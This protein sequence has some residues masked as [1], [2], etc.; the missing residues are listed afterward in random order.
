MATVERRV[1]DRTGKT[2]YVVRYRTP[3][4]ASRQKT[5]K[6]R[7]DA[8]RFVTSIESSKMT[9][10]FVDPARQ[11][12]SVADWCDK[13]LAAKTNIGPKTRERYEGILSAQIRPRWSTVKLK[14][15]RHADVQTWLAGLDLAPASVRKVHRV[16]SQAMDF[17]V[18]DGRLAVNP[19]SGVSLPR[20]ESTEKP[21]LSHEQV[22]ELAKRC[23]PGDGLIVTFLAYTGL[24][25]GEMAALRVKRLDFLRRRIVIAESVTPVKGVMTFGP[26]KGHER[27]EVP[28]PRFLAADLSRLV[29]GKGPDD[30]VFT[31]E[32]GAPMRS[33]AFQRRSLTAASTA[34]GLEGFT[35]HELR[36]SAASLAIASGADVKV[37]QT[38]LGHK[39]ATMTLDLYGHL[40]GDRLDVV[41]DAMD[42][43]RTEALSK[44]RVG[45]VLKLA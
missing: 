45:N 17:A 25:W 7:R 12:V 26:T 2:V 15:V 4:R 36:H 16:L 14:D 32:R 9:G 39:S 43:A 31:G 24:R 27:R 41:A 38:M 20:V 42:V 21:F 35:P 22:A 6:L 23:G 3:E 19:A 33:Q 44:P 18:K 11:E 13:W 8:D 34:M 40:F 5:F 10:A 37:V 28:M 30:L 29:D 1:S